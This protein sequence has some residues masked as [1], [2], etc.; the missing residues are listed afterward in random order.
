MIDEAQR[1]RFY[2]KLGEALGVEEAATLVTL[3]FGA[4]PELVSK[5]D[6]S[7]LRK[8]MEQRVAREVDSM[9]DLF[10]EQAARSTEDRPPHAQR[11]DSIERRL[12]RLERKA[13]V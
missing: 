10:D 11:L 1:L 7:S 9:C 3:W 8:E 2:C 4:E 12:D 5:D 6:L 13:K